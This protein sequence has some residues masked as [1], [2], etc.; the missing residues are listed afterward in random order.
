MEERKVICPHCGKD[1][2]IELV[3]QNVEKI[4]LGIGMKVSKPAGEEKKKSEKKKKN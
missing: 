3:I 4:E 2:N 1:I